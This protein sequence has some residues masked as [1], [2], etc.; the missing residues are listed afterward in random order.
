VGKRE[1]ADYD[2]V[3][4]HLSSENLKRELGLSRLSRNFEIVLMVREIV[5]VNFFDEELYQRNFESQRCKA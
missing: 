2:D 5:S 4:E 1:S 3:V